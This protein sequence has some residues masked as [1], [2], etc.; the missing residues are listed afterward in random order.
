MEA[1]FF[2]RF[3]KLFFYLQISTISS[4]C[5][6]R[7]SGAQSKDALL[8]FFGIGLIAGIP[9][10]SK[11]LTFILMINDHFRSLTL[12]S[13]VFESKRLE[14]VRPLSKF[15]SRL[16]PGSHWKIKWRMPHVHVATHSGTAFRSC[17]TRFLRQWPHHTR[18]KDIVDHQG[19]G[20]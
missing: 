11:P 14:I 7:I 20:D 1:K 12:F 8:F 16:I 4:F 9:A 15:H 5:F 19:F 10:T 13:Q 18:G 2:I 17:F 6:R 3:W